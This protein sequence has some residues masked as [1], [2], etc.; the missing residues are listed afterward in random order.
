MVSLQKK[1]LYCKEQK[2]DDLQHL[3]NTHANK[4]NILL[5]DISGKLDSLISLM[6]EMSS[7][8]RDLLSF[9]V[10]IDRREMGMDDVNSKEYLTELT[11]D[12]FEPR[13]E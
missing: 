12:G 11:K 13:T 9:F 7:S 4:Q 8:Q 10:A 1:L 6:K 2:M 3:A 5:G